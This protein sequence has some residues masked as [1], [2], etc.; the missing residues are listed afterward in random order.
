MRKLVVVVAVL[1]KYLVHDDL[2]SHP[3]LSTND[4]RK[5][6]KGFLDVSDELVHVLCALLILK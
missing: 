3:N 5:L 2:G 1:E 6:G 4:Q